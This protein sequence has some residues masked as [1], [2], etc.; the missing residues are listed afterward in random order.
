MVL[1]TLVNVDDDTVDAYSEELQKLYERNK[2]KGED[3]IRFCALKD[4]FECDDLDIT[5]EYLKDFHVDYHL[6]TKIDAKTEI[7]RKLMI[8]CCDVDS[9]KLYDDIKTPGHPRLKLYRGF[10]KFMENDLYNTAEAKELSRKKYKKL[11]SKIAFEMIKRNDAYSNLVELF[12]PFHLRLS[13]HAHNNSGPKFAVRLLPKDSCQTIEAFGLQSNIDEGGV[14]VDD[15]LHVPT[16]WHNAVLKLEESNS[17]V[18]GKSGSIRKVLEKEGY[19]GLWDD[20]DRCF[21]LQLK[22]TDN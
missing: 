16:P 10:M 6:N 13:I 2:P 7:Y 21:Q 17:Y 15:Y 20:L 19:S 5:K 18:I 9:H 3:C 4:I 11:V 22:L 12:F 14:C 1:T 8:K